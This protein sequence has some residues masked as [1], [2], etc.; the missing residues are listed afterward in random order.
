MVRVHVALD[1]C[2]KPQNVLDIFAPPDQRLPAAMYVEEDQM[3]TMQHKKSAALPDAVI[4]TINFL[5]HSPTKQHAQRLVLAVLVNFGHA[6]LRFH[7]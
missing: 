5:E 4:I 1:L 2:R 7:S 3:E 6:L